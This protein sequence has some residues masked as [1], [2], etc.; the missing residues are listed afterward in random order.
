ME[1]LFGL[2]LK[3]KAADFAMKCDEVGLSVRM[4]ANDGV[5]ITIAEKTANDRLIEVALKFRD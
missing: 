5:R 1:T 4:F 3:E 2:D